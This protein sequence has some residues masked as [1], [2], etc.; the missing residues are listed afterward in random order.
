MSTATIKQ[1]ISRAVVETEFRELLFAEP[2]KALAE[3][4]LTAQERAI[5]QNL[6]PTEFD[7]LA[8]NL[9]ERIS[10]SKGTLRTYYT[11]HIETQDC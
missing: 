11:C 10:R 3:Y 4:E 6:S 9:E 7:A 2:T 8:S 5:F 1:I